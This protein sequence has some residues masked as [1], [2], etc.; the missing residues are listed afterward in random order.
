MGRDLRRVPLDFKWPLN[1][2]WGGYLNPYTKQSAECAA[3]KGSGSSPESRRL[4]DEWYGKAPFDAAA[5]GA[6]PLTVD[7]PSVQAAAQ[8]NCGHAPDYYG[9][10]AGAVRSEARRLLNHFK[11]A[12]CY[13]LIQADVD[14]LV[15]GGRLHE[16]TR[17]AR[18]PDQHAVLTLQRAAGKG[19]W[20]PEHN[21]YTPTAEEINAWAMLGMGHDALNAW[22]CIEARL[23]REGYDPETKCVDCDGEGCMWPSQAIKAAAEEWESSEPPTGEGYQLWETTSEG[24]PISPVFSTLDALCVYA[25]ANCS[26]FGSE[27]ATAREWRRMLDADFVCHEETL[28]NGIRMIML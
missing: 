10:G 6:T 2:V 4:H 22:I 13:N 12:W 18:T 11:G 28:P 15:A 23:I 17:V 16:F 24:S 19:Y 14:A 8:R 3:C 26:V 9:A 21:G 27:K 25:A 5:Y 1:K 20:L 7:H